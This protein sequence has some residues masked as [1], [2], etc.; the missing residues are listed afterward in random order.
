MLL[1]GRINKY[2]ELEYHVKCNYK[3]VISSNNFVLNF[4]KI[5][6]C[7]KFREITIDSNGL[8]DQLYK[9]NTQN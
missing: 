1:L 3:R 4:Y 5:K 8:E 9:S 2:F 7:V 6:Q